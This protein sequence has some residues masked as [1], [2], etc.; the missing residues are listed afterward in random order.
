MLRQGYVIWEV[1]TATWGNVV[2]VNVSSVTIH[3]LEEV[4][5]FA[6]YDVYA[7]NTIARLVQE[8]YYVQKL[9]NFKPAIVNLNLST[10]ATK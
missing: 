6:L 5:M 2:D 10:I 4:G 8:K 7:G 3:V 1:E 9:T